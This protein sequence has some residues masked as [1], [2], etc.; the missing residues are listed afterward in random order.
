MPSLNEPILIDTPQ[1]I[2]HPFGAGQMKKIKSLSQDILQLFSSENP[3][4]FL[5]HKQ[6]TNAA[7]AEVLLHTAL[8]NQFNGMGQWYLITEKTNGKTIGIIELITPSRAKQYYQLEDYPYILEF[9]L[10]NGYTGKGIMGRVLP[11]FIES[12]KKKGINHI[13]AVVD[14]KNLKAI[15]VLEKS[16]INKQ[17]KFNSISSLYHN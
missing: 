16:G 15:K 8:F 14:P 9:C 12:L 6:L 5:Q 10:A 17:S 13:G 7:Q 3:H 2:L 4:F 1:F 11:K